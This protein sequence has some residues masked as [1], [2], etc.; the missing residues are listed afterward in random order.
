MFAQTYL[1]TLVASFSFI[2][3]VGFRLSSSLL[4]T[5]PSI[6]RNGTF[7]KARTIYLSLHQFIC[8]FFCILVFFCFRDGL[9]MILHFFEVISI[10]LWRLCFKLSLWTET[11]VFIWL[12]FGLFDSLVDF[13]GHGGHLLFDFFYVLE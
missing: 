4:L 1:Y 3:K 8:I 5:R 7:L 9:M 11:A 13:D 10:F 12:F 6:S 2:L